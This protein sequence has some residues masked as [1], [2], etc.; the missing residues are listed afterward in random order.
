MLGFTPICLSPSPCTPSVS[1]PATLA[2]ET[3]GRAHAGHHRAGP[4]KILTEKQDSR[5]LCSLNH[6]SP[7]GLDILETLDKGKCTAGFLHSLFR[8]HPFR[9]QPSQAHMY[10]LQSSV[11]WYFH[12]ALKLLLLCL[13]VVP[14]I[15]CKVLD[16][17]DDVLF[18]FVLPIWVWFLS[19]WDRIG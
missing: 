13:P 2:W 5:A 8:N 1:D 17:K 6:T 3:P 9:D 4:C 19:H 11:Y 18:A 10:N 16:R 15:V 7:R 14:S 12:L